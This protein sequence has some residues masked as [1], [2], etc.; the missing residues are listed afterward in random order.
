MTTGGSA[1]Y[2]TSLLPLCEILG[3]IEVVPVFLSRTTWFTSPKGVPYSAPEWDSSAG[4]SIGSDSS[5]ILLPL[6]YLPFPFLAYFFPGFTVFDF[7]LGAS[8]KTSSP[9]ASDSKSYYFVFG[10]T[11]LCFFLY[12]YTSASSISSDEASF[13]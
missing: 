10:F 12:F 11:V 9:F 1:S 3:V 5:S 7:A 4:F 2:S 6:S 13:F 8:A